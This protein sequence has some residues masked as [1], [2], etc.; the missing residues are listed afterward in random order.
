MANPPSGSPPPSLH[1][2]S[3]SPNPPESAESTVVAIENSPYRDSRN[4]GEF[5]GNNFAEDLRSDGSVD[6]AKGEAPSAPS[7]AEGEA[8]SPD[9]LPEKASPSVPL[10]TE[11]IATQ[12][13]HP[14]GCENATD[15]VA[16][17]VAK[18]T[19]GVKRATEKTMWQRENNATQ[20][21]RY[22]KIVSMRRPDGRGSTF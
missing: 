11:T 18:L 10:N 2:P 13:T 12:P 19:K 4:R 8:S 21:S 20:A 15:L 17:M 7:P 3:T 9:P 22:R 6:P 16:E 5:S 14:R 1:S